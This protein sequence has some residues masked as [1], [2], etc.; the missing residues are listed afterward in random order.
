[1]RSIWQLS[2]AT[3]IAC[4]GLQ[5]CP[6]PLL[7]APVVSSQSAI[8]PTKESLSQRLIGTWR[9]VKQGDRVVTGTPNAQRLKFFTGKQWNITQADLKTKKVIFHHGGTYSLKDDVMTSNVDYANESTAFRIGTVSRFKV[10]VQGDTYQQIGLDNP[11]TET[12]QRVK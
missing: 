7:A 3:T 1:M 11:Y 8:T 5:L 6:T 4:I 12:W 10:D 2:A 9:L